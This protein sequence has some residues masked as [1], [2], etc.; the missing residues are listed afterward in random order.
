MAGVDLRPRFTAASMGQCLVFRAYDS[1]R[2]ADAHR[3]S[4]ARAL[5]A[6]GSVLMGVEQTRGAQARGM[7]PDVTAPRCLADDFKSIRRLAYSRGGFVDLACPGPFR[8]DSAQRMDPRVPT[9][10][11]LRV[12][13]V[14]LVGG[15]SRARTSDGFR[16]RRT[17]HVYHCPPQ[18]LVRRFTHLNAFG[19]VFIVRRTNRRLGPD[20]AGRPANRRSYYVDPRRVGL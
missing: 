1:A 12:G 6:V 15:H 11:L 9:R 13:F 5:T 10:K 2:G 8:R 7:E 16:S 18:R 20:P 14:I 4:A 17:L 19:L 3:G